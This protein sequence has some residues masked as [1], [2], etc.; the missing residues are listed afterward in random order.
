AFNDDFS[1]NSFR[2]DGPDYQESEFPCEHEVSITEDVRALIEWVRPNDL[3]ATIRDSVEYS[4][5]NSEILAR[6]AMLF[7]VSLNSFRNKEG[8]HPKCMVSLR[9]GMYG[10]IIAFVLVTCAGM[11]HVMETSTSAIRSQA[12]E[13]CNQALE[14]QTSTVD[15]L[16][17]DNV[18]AKTFDKAL[19]AISTSFKKHIFVPADRGLESIWGSLRT[20]RLM[21]SWDGNIEDIKDEILYRIWVELDSQWSL[22]DGPFGSRPT[23]VPDQQEVLKN[24]LEGLSIIGL[25]GQ[26]AGMAGSSFSVD[27]PGAGPTMCGSCRGKCHHLDLHS[28]NS[29]AVE[30]GLTT[31]VSR[32]VEASTGRRVGDP[33]L[34]LQHNWRKV[35]GF[36]VQQQYAD[37]AQR[38]SSPVE[39]QKMWSKL[40]Q[41]ADGITRMSWTAPISDCGSYSCFSGVIS[42]DVML[43]T[44]STDCTEELAKLSKMLH[45]GYNYPLGEGNSSM[46][47]VNHVSD[48]FPEQIGT[49][50]GTAHNPS[51]KPVFR[52]AT[53]I[54]QGDPH[55]ELI[56]AASR[57]ILAKNSRWDGEEL[58]QPQ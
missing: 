21:G 51:S 23:P 4:E 24:Q 35:P 19:G 25:A 15:K 48:R 14:V 13:T 2:Q 27:C 57:A 45:S 20:L 32:G 50:L 56:A 49:L 16:V 40:F 18:T 46:F 26:S 17:S 55:E 5:H 41:F 38:S 30:S 31:L 44:V 28:S 52:N 37:E 9:R 34:V 53:E 10:L 1:L 42:A 7:P 58:L 12:I 22:Q 29:P 43:G 11:Y 8:D 36:E 3:S 33:L 6:A 54:S 39:A 47:V